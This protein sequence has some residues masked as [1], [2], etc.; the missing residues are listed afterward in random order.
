[1]VA[2]VSGLEARSLQEE[3]YQTIVD[4][5]EAQP[6]MALQAQSNACQRELGIACLLLKL[7]VITCVFGLIRCRANMQCLISWT[8]ARVAEVVSVWSWLWKSS[9]VGT[10]AVQGL[11]QTRLESTPAGPEATQ[12]MARSNRNPCQSLLLSSAMALDP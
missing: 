8:L 2:K 1:M 9:F 4:Q 5:D 6:E 12:E 10:D 7:G 3:V 11:A